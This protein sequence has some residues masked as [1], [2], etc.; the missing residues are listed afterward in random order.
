MLE[1]LWQS[2]ITC[3]AAGITF[4]WETIQVLLDQVLSSFFPCEEGCSKAESHFSQ[5]YFSD[6]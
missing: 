5:P 1:V 6:K 2:M 3:R 4:P